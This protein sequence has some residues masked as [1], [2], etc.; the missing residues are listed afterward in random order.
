MEEGKQEKTSKSL[1]NKTNPDLLDKLSCDMN[2]SSIAIAMLSVFVFSAGTSIRDKVQYRKV[3]LATYIL[4]LMIF[5]LSL[6]PAI[7]ALNILKT[8]EAKAAFAEKSEEAQ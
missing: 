3:I 1:P 4:A 6:I 7:Y 5:P 8:P 2:Y